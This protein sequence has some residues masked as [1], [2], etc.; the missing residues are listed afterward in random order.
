MVREAS[1]VQYFNPRI[2]LI[3]DATSTCF[4]FINIVQ[5]SLHM[6]LVLVRKGWVGKTLYLTDGS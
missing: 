3:F 6:I 5:V 4:C 2:A 1:Q